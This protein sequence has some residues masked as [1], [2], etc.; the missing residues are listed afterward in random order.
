MRNKTTILY[1]ALLAVLIGYGCKDQHPVEPN[2]L[3]E[4]TVNKEIIGTLEL[5][6]NSKFTF[7]AVDS[8]HTD[9][10]GRYSLIEDE[11]TFEDDTCQNPGTYQYIIGKDVLTFTLKDDTCEQRAQVITGTW[12]LK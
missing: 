2:G 12:T 4:K 5:E 10:K 7:T 3:W 9:S 1:V 6:E 8:K 11:I